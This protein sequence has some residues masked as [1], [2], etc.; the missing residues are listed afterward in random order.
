MTLAEFLFRSMAVVTM[1]ALTWI[2]A[3][4]GFYMEWS[5]WIILLVWTGIIFLG[6]LLLD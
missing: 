2:V 1:S 4:M 6:D 5:G 3:N